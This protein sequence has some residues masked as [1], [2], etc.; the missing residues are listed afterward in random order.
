MKTAI[1]IPDPTFEAAET[2]ATRLGMSRSELYAKAVNDY[3]NSHKYQ[4]VTKT[5][6]QVYDEQPESIEN[7]FLTMQVGSLPKDDW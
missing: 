7:E 4:D 5:L 2:L 3:I 1:S 6:N